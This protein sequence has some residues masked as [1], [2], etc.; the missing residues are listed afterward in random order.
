M[1]KF[2]GIFLGSWVALSNVPSAHADGLPVVI[3]ATV[4]Y[5]S[6]TLTISGQN[7]GNNPEWPSMI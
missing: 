3:S 7:F 6:G 5:T 2:I 4:N 1:Q